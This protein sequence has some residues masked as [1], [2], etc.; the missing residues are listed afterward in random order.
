MML[1]DSHKA[2]FRQPM[3][4]AVAG[5]QVTIRFQCDEAT[6]V[7]LRT[8]Q[9]EE[10]CYVMINTGDNVWETSVVLPENPGL[11]WYRFIVY[12]MDGRTLT[13]GNKPDHL[14]GEGMIYTEGEAESFQITVY[15]KAFT[16]PSYFHSANIYQIFPDRFFRSKTEAKDDRQDRYLHEKWDE[17]MLS[18]GDMRGGRYQELDFYGGNLNGVRADRKSVV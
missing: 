18:V 15:D 9:D 7:I 2:F 11:Y 12:R 6:A 8:W 16:T 3:G 14:G 1:H 10:L 17:E 13:Y 5:S 4:P